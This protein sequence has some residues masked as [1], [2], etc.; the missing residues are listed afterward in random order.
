MQCGA[1]CFVVEIEKEGKTTQHAID[2]R[3]PASARKAIRRKYGKEIRILS[4]LKKKKLH[5]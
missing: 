1:K 4:A 2:A 3:S 5:P